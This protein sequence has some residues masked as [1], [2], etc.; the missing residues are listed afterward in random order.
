MHLNHLNLPVDD[1]AA[2][3]DLFQ[4]L[5]GFTLTR[6]GGDTLAILEDGHG[7]P[8]VLANAARFGGEIPVYPGGFHVG[9]TVDDP[10]EVDAVYRR[11]AAAGHPLDYEPRRQRSSYGFYVHAPG[12]SLVEGATSSRSRRT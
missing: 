7:I 8:L 5:L 2:A 4:E 6:D 12:G 9:F 1:L 10:V 11:L 3:N